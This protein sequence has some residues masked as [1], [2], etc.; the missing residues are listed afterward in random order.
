M[1]TKVQQKPKIEE[2][3]TKPQKINENRKKKTP[4]IQQVNE[5]HELLPITLFGIKSP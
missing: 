2:R 3:K 5:Q 1:I 4:H